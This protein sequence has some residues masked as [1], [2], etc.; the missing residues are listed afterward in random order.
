MISEMYKVHRQFIKS[1]NKYLLDWQLV[2]LSMKNLKIEQKIP[3]L[4]EYFLIDRSYNK[5]CRVLNYIQACNIS[6]EIN[7]KNIFLFLTWCKENICFEE[8]RNSETFSKYNT[9][10]L[11]KLFKE[12][13]GRNNKWV[14]GGYFHPLQIQFLKDL[15]SY[16]E[17]EY[18]QAVTENFDYKFKF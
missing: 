10:I 4:K 17:I 15:A 12:L 13:T 11:K 9:E 5:F 2:R 8:E 16:L 7:D 18:K 14:K 1:V 6:Q 3:I